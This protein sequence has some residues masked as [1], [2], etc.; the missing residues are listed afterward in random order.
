MGQ[1]VVEKKKARELSLDE[2]RA[3]L[4]AVEKKIKAGTELSEKDW[5]TLDRAR[6]V[7]FEKALKGENPALAL[8]VFFSAV[9]LISQAYQN[10]VDAGKTLETADLERMANTSNQL[11]SLLHPAVIKQNKQLEHAFTTGGF[12]ILTYRA[13]INRLLDDFERV[14]VANT[15]NSAEADLPHFLQGI[16]QAVSVIQL[17]EVAKTM[18]AMEERLARYRYETM[19][20][21]GLEPRREFAKYVREKIMTPA[22]KERYQ[23]A[24]EE[25]E[26]VKEAFRKKIQLILNELEKEANKLGKLRTIDDVEKVI[27]LSERLLFLRVQT[28]PELYALLD[29]KQKSQVDGIIIA[30][31]NKVDE[32]VNWINSELSKIR[33]RR[34]IAK[35]VDV[36]VLEELGGKPITKEI[37]AELRKKGVSEEILKKL[38]EGER[39]DRKT[40][41]EL[42]KEG[43]D[44]QTLVK[45]GGLIG[46][47]ERKYLYRDW[48]EVTPT[49]KPREELFEIPP[50][51][52]VRELPEI[53]NI[54]GVPLAD[55]WVSPKTFDKKVLESKANFSINENYSDEFLTNRVLNNVFGGDTKKR[56]DFLDMINS[57]TTVNVAKALSILPDKW[58]T[59]P[60]GGQLSQDELTTFRNLLNRLQN[61]PGDVN[62]QMAFMQFMANVKNNHPGSKLVQWFNANGFTNSYRNYV[63]QRRLRLVTDGMT[64][65]GERFAVGFGRMYDIPYMYSET[66]ESRTIVDANGIIEEETSPHNKMVAKVGEV[67]GYWGQITFALDKNGLPVP[68]TISIKYGRAKGE[69]P[70]P[71]PGLEEYLR[72]QVTTT[73]LEVEWYNNPLKVESLVGAIASIVRWGGKG[74][75]TLL[76]RTIERAN[77]E[78]IKREYGTT[79]AGGITQ[80]LF[81]TRDFN[82]ITKNIILITS[83]QANILYS[84]GE[85]RFVPTFIQ[86]IYSTWRDFTLTG[87]FTLDKDMLSGKLRPDIRGEIGFT[88]YS[89]NNLTLRF[90][91]GGGYVEREISEITAGLE[92]TPKKGPKIGLKVFYTPKKR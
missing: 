88:V 49:L 85:L 50:L 81:D 26:K 71:Q 65:S 80:R 8:Q 35:P 5:K 62:A 23:K 37:I 16:E 60:E 7:A 31:A 77:L 22:Q 76:P 25:F 40:L 12:G 24:C 70:V 78:I 9:T 83:W 90:N 2:L 72:Q 66:W 57:G 6:D 54:V 10:K 21:E 58:L 79:W 55:I 75:Y 87:A 17:Y 1:K 64:V 29:D 11:I 20:I 42:E 61:N 36:E 14:C 73:L 47:L 68:G 69:V 74:H 56:N 63:T 46:I 92:F 86:T 13:Q 30:L 28:A 59:D 33:A 82:L 27:K 41:Q 18:W 48:F 43:V 38:K 51:R 4:K 44:E 84:P 19:D 32:A 67:K 15:L 45:L 53:P 34:E 91:L 39:I 52:N 89:S 3:S